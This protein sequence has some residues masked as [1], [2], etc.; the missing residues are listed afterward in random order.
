MKATIF[1][2]KKYKKITLYQT[3]KNKVKKEKKTSNYSSELMHASVFDSNIN[4]PYVN[5]KD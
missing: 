2:R 5:N 1:Q 3:P 4:K